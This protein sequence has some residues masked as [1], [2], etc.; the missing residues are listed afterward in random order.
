MLLVD[1]VIGELDA[2]GRAA[3]FA[4]LAEADQVFLASTPASAPSGLSPAS[5][6]TVSSG[7][8]TAKSVEDTGSS[9]CIEAS[10]AVD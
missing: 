3:F 1:D 8:V 2:R 6:F 5:E 10:S 7:V 9:D 4:S